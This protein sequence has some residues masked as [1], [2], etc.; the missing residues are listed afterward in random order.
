MYGPPTSGKSSLSESLKN[1]YSLDYD[2]LKKHKLGKGNFSEYLETNA[3]KFNIL[4]MLNYFTHVTERHGNKY[5]VPRKRINKTNN[6]LIISTASASEVNKIQ[7]AASRVNLPCVIIVLMN[8]KESAVKRLAERKLPPHEHDD[9][10]NLWLSTYYYQNA[11][12]QPHLIVNSDLMSL[13]ME[14][15]IVDFTINKYFIDYYSKLGAV[16]K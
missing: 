9:R 11:G 16:Q 15:D 12:F 2:L 3:T 14:T 1:K 8:S 4:S 7:R 10:M 13:E 6:K 5:G